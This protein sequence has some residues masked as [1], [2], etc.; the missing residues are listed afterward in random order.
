MLG[1]WTLKLLKFFLKV[2]KFHKPWNTFPTLSEYFRDTQATCFAK[3]T[4]A[5]TSNFEICEFPRFSKNKGPVMQYVSQCSCCFV[6][7]VREFIMLVI[8]TRKSVKLCIVELHEHLCRIELSY[9][10]DGLKIHVFYYKI[11][12]VS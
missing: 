9:V 6:D 2:K 10:Y 5:G 3:K 8:S 4:L 1:E 12:F 11:L 7:S